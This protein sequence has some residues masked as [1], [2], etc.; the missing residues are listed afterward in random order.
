MK[1]NRSSYSLLYK[2]V[3][4][5]FLMNFLVSFIFF[6]FIFFVNQIL[7]LVR[8][9][10]LKN[11][12][13]KTMLVLVL[14]AIPQFLLYV[15]P[16]A[17]LSASS[18]VLGDLG[19]SNELLAMRSVGIAMR[20]V[21]RMLLVLAL[22]LSCFTFFVADFVL[23]Y[24]AQVYRDR[25]ASVMR[26]MPTFEIQS[27][28]INRV[29]DII[30]SNGQVEGD[31]IND[32]LLIKQGSDNEQ[33]VSAKSG[34]LDLIDSER[35]IYRLELEKPKILFTQSNIDEWGVSDSEKAVLYLDFSSQVPS[36]TSTS[37]S[38]LSSRSL[39]ALIEE[40]KVVKEKDIDSYHK[41]KEAQKARLAQVVSNIDSLSDYSSYQNTL[42]L[43]LNALTA[44]G[45]KEPINFYYQYYTAELHKKLVLS[46]ACFALTMVTLPLS[47]IR[48]RYGRLFGFGISVLLA[49]LFWYMLFFSQME[50]FNVNFSSAFLMWI[51]DVFML[52]LSGML[53]FMKRKS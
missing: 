33:T 18:M 4:K 37:P 23:P 9:V 16:F 31:I 47:F 44:L 30:M 19:A 25:L 50:I 46:F 40:R 28:G 27:N 24:S 38:Q 34:H 14:C 26:E 2:Y 5:E 53:L 48:I 7:L 41:S 42:S 22:I 3:T 11:V 13:F 6:F 49:V 51:P 45:E 10:L 21:Y 52:L 35:F 36:L 1:K 32:I 12:D 20:K 29:G 43:S 8:R 15:I 17:T 39:L